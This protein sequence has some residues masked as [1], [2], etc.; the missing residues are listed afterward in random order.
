MLEKQKDAVREVEMRPSDG[1]ARGEAKLVW[2]IP[3]RDRARRSQA[4]IL[5]IKCNLLI[6]WTP[7]KQYTKGEDWLTILFAKGEGGE[8]E[9]ESPAYVT[10]DSLVGVPGLEPGKTG[11]ESVVLPIT[12]YPN[13]WRLSLQDTLP[14]LAFL[15]VCVC[16]FTALFYAT[17]LFSWFFVFFWLEKSGFAN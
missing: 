14:H 16:K 1:A 10:D 6:Y 5:W 17:I 2:I 4:D 15:L 12:P 8:T 9:K 3:S 7:H 11:P 13:H